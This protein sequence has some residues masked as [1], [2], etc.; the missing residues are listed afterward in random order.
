[1]KSHVFALALA[2]LSP[3]ISF[4]APPVEVPWAQGTVK[5][6][7]RAG[8]RATIAHGPIDSIGM[9]PMTMMFAVKDSAGLARLKEGDPVR[10]QAVMAG[11]DIVVTRIE[12]LK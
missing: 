7:D 4:A 9:G 2:L 8:A 5:K 10:F 1:M 6:I 11:G 3:S 12:S